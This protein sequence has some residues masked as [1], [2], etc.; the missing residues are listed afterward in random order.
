MRLAVNQDNCS[1]CRTCELVCALENFRENNPKMSR[2]RIHGEFPAPGKYRVSHCT[3]C[4]TCQEV[5]PVDAIEETGGGYYR[6]L[7]DE[8]IGCMAC[9]EECPE[10]VVFTH[11]A[12]D[13]PFMCNGCGSCVE[14]CP[15]NAIYDADDPGRT[16]YKEFEE[17]D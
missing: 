15:R 6:V 1:G 9:V 11:D 3:Q 4:G 17:V 13:V 8:C 5:C 16:R 14:I 10:G 2:L 12:I 7:E